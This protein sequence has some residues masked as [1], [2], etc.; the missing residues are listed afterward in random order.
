MPDMAPNSCNLYSVDVA[1]AGT[2]D[3]LVADAQRLGQT[4]TRRMIRDWT[5]AGL[6]DFPAKRSAGKGHGSRP[7]LYSAN[8][9]E[10]FAKLLHHR[11]HNG[12]RSLARI[13]V[14]IWMNWDESYVPLRQARLALTTWLGDTQTSM[15]KAQH[16]A[17]EMLGQLDHPQATPAARKRLVAVLTN[18]AYTGRADLNELEEAVHTVFE[19][20]HS[21][22][23]RAIGHPEAAL[24]TDTV[25]HL[26]RARLT[27]ISL[28]RNNAI[29]D[30]NL[31]DARHAHRISFAEYTGKQP[32]LATHA[33]ASSPGMYEPPNPDLALAHCC[34]HLLT[35]LGLQ[36][37]H[38]ETADRI[39]RLPAPQSAPW[40]S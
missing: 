24:T 27:A 4:V 36:A 12:I 35:L 10:L 30:D 7:A 15:K 32:I 9:R 1:E 13:P 25:V 19:P 40:S 31:R 2:L 17:R 20:G 23:H 39:N 37:L 6:L 38:P 3:D 26:L 34:G 29:T 33:P 22:I 21:Q 8:Q 28:L 11:P 18:L 5:A 14:F 16:T